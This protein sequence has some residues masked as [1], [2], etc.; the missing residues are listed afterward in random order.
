MSS[1]C[2]Y[3]SNE[4]NFVSKKTHVQL[5]LVIKAWMTLSQNLY[6]C[7]RGIFK[8]GIFNV[9][10]WG[11]SV[12][13]RPGMNHEDGS[14]KKEDPENED[15]PTKNKD[16]LQKWRPITKTKTPYKNSLE[17]FLEHSIAKYQKFPSQITVFGTSCKWPP[18]ISNCDHF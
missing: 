18:L 2:Y 11:K 12:N 1:L 5:M 4:L 14:I 13:S 3:V 9:F 10:L 16:H 15:P 17:F 8:N 7:D 6:Y